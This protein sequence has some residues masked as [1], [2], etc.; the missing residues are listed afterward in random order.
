[1]VV[2]KQIVFIYQSYIKMDAKMV[3][4]IRGNHFRFGSVFT[5]KNNQNWNLEKQKQKPKTEPKPVQTDRFQFDSVRFFMSKN[6]KNLYYF[7]SFWT[8]EECLDELLYFP[9]SMQSKALTHPNGVEP[10]LSFLHSL[11][12]LDTPSS[13]PT[14]FNSN[15]DEPWQGW[16]D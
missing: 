2:K 6:Q 3:S 12:L 1:M 14:F 5:N 16:M 13:I 11:H 15:S 10:L 9:F 4:R 7:F 8:G